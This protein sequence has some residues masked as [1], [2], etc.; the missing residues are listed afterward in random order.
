M[1]ESATQF[2]NNWLKDLDYINLTMRS[3]RKVQC[4][5]NILDLCINNQEVLDKI[6]EGYLFDKILRADGLYQ[7]VVYLPLL[8]LSARLTIRDNITEYHKSQFKLYIF[9]N[10][11]KFKKKIRLQLL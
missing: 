3:I 11:E 6:Y 9:N 10:E 8:R 2:Y 1:S 4:D 7:Y 5:C